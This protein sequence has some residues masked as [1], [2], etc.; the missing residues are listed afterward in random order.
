MNIFLL[1][2]GLGD[3]DRFTAHLHY[4]IECVPGVGQAMVDKLLGLAGRSSSTF[5]NSKDHPGT[6]PQNRPDFVLTCNDVDI[7][8]EHKLESPLGERQLER[9]LAMQW[10]RPRHL[11]LISNVHCGVASE[12]LQHSQYLRPVHASHYLW[13]DIY[14]MLD[15]NDGRIVRDFATYMRS[16]GMKPLELANGWSTLFEDRA[17]AE[18]FGEQF[19]RVRDYFAKQGARCKI[20]ANRCGFQISRP[21]PWLHLMYLFVEP[22]GRTSLGIEDAVLGARIYVQSTAPEAAAFRQNE[23]ELQLGRHRVRMRARDK[24]ASW[25]SELHLVFE[26]LAPLGPVLSEDVEAIQESLLEFAKG[27]FEHCQSLVCV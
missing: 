18:T 15:P 7:V 9:Y 12:V 1:P 8:C 10:N 20:D 24:V 16:L 25:N 23:L 17:T 21:A 27:V 19:R 4:L 11:A 14:G 13:R 5:T 26:Y 3:E 2:E 22:A 6:D